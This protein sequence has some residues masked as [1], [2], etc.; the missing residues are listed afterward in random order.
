MLEADGEQFIVS[1]CVLAE[2]FWVLERSSSVSKS[3]V[4][5]IATALLSSEEFRAWDR[6]VADR[7]IELKRR[8][9]ELDIED[10]I[11][12]ARAI[13]DDD[14]VITSDRLLEKTIQTEL[15]RQERS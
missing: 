12:A 10:C 3:S 4:V 9:P 15:D 11:L 7:A 13:I 14:V 1:E 5:D 2:L 8:V 6:V